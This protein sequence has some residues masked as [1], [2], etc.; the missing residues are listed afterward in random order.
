M[1]ELGINLGA[2]TEMD[3]PTFCAHIRELGLTIDEIEANTAY[4]NSGLAV[5]SLAVT[6]TGKELRKY[7]THNEI[8]R[9]LGSLEYVNHIEEI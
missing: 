5:Y 7:K 6:I 3:I 9:A 4:L 1:R 8:I 2:R